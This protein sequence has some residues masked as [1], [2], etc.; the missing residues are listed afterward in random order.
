MEGVER[1]R[2]EQLDEGNELP[3]SYDVP[4][5]KKGYFTATVDKEL[6]TQFVVYSFNKNGYTKSEELV[7]EPIC[8]VEDFCRIRIDNDLINVSL[9]EKF[10]KQKETTFVIYSN[11]SNSVNEIKEGS[12]DASN[13]TIN[14]SDLNKGYYI[15]NIQSGERHKSVKF[16]KRN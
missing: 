5:F 4:D 13:Y 1:I 14:I 6:Y 16:V 3:I 11:S 9:Y 15:L 10:T 7:I 2:I 8:P 12:F